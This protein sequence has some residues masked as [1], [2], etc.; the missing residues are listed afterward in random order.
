MLWTVLDDVATNALEQWDY[1][2][3]FPAGYAGISQPL[4]IPS[5]TWQIE[6]QLIALTNQ[7]QFTQVLVSIETL[8]GHDSGT[9]TFSD[10][11]ANAG[12]GPRGQRIGS[13][14]RY[15]FSIGVWV[16]EQLG[17]MTMARKMSQQVIAAMFYYRNRLTTIRHINLFHSL[18]T[19]NGAAQLFN[20]N[21]TF[22]GDV[23]IT[24]DV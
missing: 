18:E 5:S 9:K 21:L 22:E 17:G 14:L 24:I 10:I 16:D 13:R 3:A 4:F 8:P 20:V 7:G 1:S 6:S 23:H 15:P 12:A 19:F 2:S 11:Y